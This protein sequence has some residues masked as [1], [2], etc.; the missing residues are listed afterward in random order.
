MNKRERVEINLSD[1][2]AGREGR[3]AKI[4]GELDEHSHQTIRGK[5]QIRRAVTV[6]LFNLHVEHYQIS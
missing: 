2:A 4:M 5:I 3:W 6:S 1:S